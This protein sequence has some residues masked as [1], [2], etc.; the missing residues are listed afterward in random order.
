MSKYTFDR[1][2]LRKKT[3]YTILKNKSPEDVMTYFTSPHLCLICPGYSVS[4]HDPNPF[5]QVLQYKAQPRP[6]QFSLS[7]P[8]QFIPIHC[9]LYLQIY[10]QSIHFSP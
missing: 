1:L 9:P 6:G 7:F 5:T 10:S 3:H 8:T 2:S 4:R